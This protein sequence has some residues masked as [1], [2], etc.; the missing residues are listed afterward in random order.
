MRN[1]NIG[2]YGLPPGD[3]YYDPRSGRNWPGFW[4][5]RSTLNCP[6]KR[7][8]I[9]VFQLAMALSLRERRLRALDTARL[10]A[11][12]PPPAL[13]EEESKVQL[14]QQITILSDS[15]DSLHNAPT[16]SFRGRRASALAKTAATQESIPKDAPAYRDTFST[17]LIEMGMAIDMG[18]KWC[19]FE[20]TEE[21]LK[22]EARAKAEADA[23]LEREHAEL[24]AE[25]EAERRAQRVKSDIITLAGGCKVTPTIY[26]TPEIDLS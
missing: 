20:P 24:A 19:A 13:G 4:F 9:V 10:K 6:I 16:D 26:P 5:P 22:A 21:E 25:E 12:A 7:I 8:R 1:E 23:A 15:A 18:I 2:S 17:N 3:H 11:R 14:S